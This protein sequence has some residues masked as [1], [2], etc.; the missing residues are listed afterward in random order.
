MSNEL[1]GV[2]DGEL[3][4]DEAAGPLIN[5]TYDLGNQPV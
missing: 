3:L 5:L 4:A 1:V 2:R